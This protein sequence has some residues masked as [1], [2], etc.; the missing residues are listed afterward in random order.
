VSEEKN[1]PKPFANVQPDRYRTS[2]LLLADGLAEADSYASDPPAPQN[3]H[4]DK[5]KGGK[6]DRSDRLIA[7][8]INSL[9]RIFAQI[10]GAIVGVVLGIVIAG[11]MTGSQNG[12]QVQQ[13]VPDLQRLSQPLEDEG[14]LQEKSQVI[15]VNGVTSSETIGQWPISGR[16][17]VIIINGKGRLILHIEPA[18][19]HQ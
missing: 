1:I 3:Q 16:S 15:F 6:K 11:Q 14:Q 10:I 18:S 4:A 12:Y 8:I 2:P 19:P 5:K 9:G 17:V 13:R 7:A